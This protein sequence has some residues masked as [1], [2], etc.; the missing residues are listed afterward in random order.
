[1]VRELAEQLKRQHDVQLEQ[2]QPTHSTEK[3]QQH[4]RILREEE[5][6]R[7]HTQ[8]SVAHH[9]SSSTI[10]LSAFKRSWANRDQ[11]EQEPTHHEPE[12]LPPVHSPNVRLTEIISIEDQESSPNKKRQQPTATQSLHTNPWEMLRDH[13][14]HLREQ[15]LALEKTK[16]SDEN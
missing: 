4:S 9:I 5:L 15:R 13:F 8:Y 16:K 1:M 2:S 7:Q 6:R 14:I 12:K 10:D 3:A 11:H